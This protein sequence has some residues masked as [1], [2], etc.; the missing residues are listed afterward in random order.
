MIGNI[1]KR[2]TAALLGLTGVGAAQAGPAYIYQIHEGVIAPDLFSG[3]DDIDNAGLF[4]AA[5]TD[6][7]GAHF[8]LTFTMILS[9]ADVEEYTLPGHWS[10]Q[11]YYGPTTASLTIN[12]HTLSYTAHDNSEIIRNITDPSHAA[13]YGATSAYAQAND[14][15]GYGFI[16]GA[17]S[18]GQMFSS[19]DQ[20]TPF[21][22]T[23]SD[24]D[25]TLSDL[26]T[27]YN[28]AYTTVLGL[29][30]DSVRGGM[31]PEPASWAMMVVG[32][33][34]SGAAMRRRKT[35]VGFA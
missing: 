31:A 18:A 24:Y 34:L 19:L 32:F 20:R 16:D 25:K 1:A 13:M 4:G 9:D 7:T 21:S 29:R 3:V 27:F 6:L 33:G 12:G 14:F 23:L 15:L 17:A 11:T 5:G 30:D 8:T 2:A 10:E 26:G 22:Y 35:I 28:S